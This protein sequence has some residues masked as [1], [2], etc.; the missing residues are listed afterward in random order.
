MFWII[1]RLFMHIISCF[2]IVLS[3]TNYIAFVLDSLT[4]LVPCK[5]CSLLG[6]HRLVG[7]WIFPYSCMRIWLLLGLAEGSFC[8]VAY[9]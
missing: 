4:S 9:N 1:K 6:K 3:H 2:E 5:Q 7:I 8:Y